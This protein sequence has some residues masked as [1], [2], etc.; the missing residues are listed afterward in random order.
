[1]SV[2][3]VLIDSED[4]VVLGPPASI[5]VSLGI[6]EQGVRGSKFFIG[7]GDPNIPGVIPSIEELILGDVFINTSTTS[8]FAWL[9]LYVF[10][11]SGNI[12]TPAL[13]LQPSIYVRNSDVTFDGSGVANIT[14]PLADIVSDTTVTDVNRF[15]VQ[16]T[17]INS[18]PVAIVVNSKSISVS[19]L[20]VN[21]EA[22]EFAS[23]VWSPLT[24]LIELGITISVV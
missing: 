19:N 24:G 9:Y 17:A 14:I 5:D 18:N 10:T 11:P 2:F 16:I 15:I 20:I 12:W 21:V 13:R 4:I 7:S 22:V 6:G 1:V 23:S 3:N 8:E